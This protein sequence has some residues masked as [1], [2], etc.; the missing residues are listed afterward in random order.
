[1]ELNGTDFLIN[2]VDLSASLVPKADVPTYIAEV[3]FSID[4]PFINLV[5]LAD[6]L[7]MVVVGDL[8]SKEFKISVT[9]ADGDDNIKLKGYGLSWGVPVTVLDDSF[10]LELKLWCELLDA[11]I[12][13][14]SRLQSKTWIEIDDSLSG[15]EI[16]AVWERKW[17]L[18]IEEC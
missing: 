16:N 3:E 18:C 10:I 17:L 7:E 9:S 4:L 6:F 2:I 11:D 8:D 15:A 12:M 5:S 14:I 13:N 1:M